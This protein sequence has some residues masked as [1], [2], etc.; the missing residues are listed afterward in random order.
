MKYK[1]NIIDVFAEH[2]NTFHVQQFDKGHIYQQTECHSG[3][4]ATIFQSQQLSIRLSWHAIS[5][6]DK[7]IF[8]VGGKSQDCQF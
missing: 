8:A 2:K 7:F 6:P 1:H 3:I 5:H 4:I